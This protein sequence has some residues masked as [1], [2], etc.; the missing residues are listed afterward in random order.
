MEQMLEPLRTSVLTNMEGGQLM[1]RHLNDLGTIDPS[2]LTDAP[3]NAYLE[4]LQIYA[5]RYEKALALVRKSEETVK[6]QLADVVRDRAVNAFG[7]ALK[8]YALSDSLEEVEASRSLQILFGSFK[9]LS[10]LNYEAETIAIDKLLFE[11]AGANYFP[12]IKLLQMERYVVRINNSNAVFKNLFGGRM[13]TS[14]LAETYDLKRIRKEMFKKY[15]EFC[16]Y[17]LTMSKAINS[18]LFNSALE[19]LN[20]ARKYNSDFLARRHASKAEAITAAV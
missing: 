9:D 19:L 18:P 8:L 13:V 2:L 17:V 12:K 6:I 10:D 11:L 14:A 3:F 20:S 15:G 4:S 7:K 1:K 5:D 16:N